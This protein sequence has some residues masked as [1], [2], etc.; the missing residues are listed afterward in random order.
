MLCNEKTKQH[1]EKVIGIMSRKEMENYCKENKLR[2]SIHGTTNK[3]TLMINIYEYWFDK[4]YSEHND[5]IVNGFLASDIDFLQTIWLRYTRCNW[6][7]ITLG[8]YRGQL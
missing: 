7:S 6:S 2:K 5:Y 4:M 8:E 3:Y 1:F